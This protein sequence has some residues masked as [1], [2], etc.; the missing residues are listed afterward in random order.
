MI[1][2]SFDRVARLNHALPIPMDL[3]PDVGSRT[4]ILYH[5]LWKGSPTAPPFEELAPV[6][7]ESVKWVCAVHP[8][9][10]AEGSHA[11]NIDAFLAVLQQR[12]P[13]RTVSPRDYLRSK[14]RNRC[15]PSAGI[16]AIRDLL[17]FGIKEL[18]ISGFTFYQGKKP[19]HENYR[20]AGPTPW[21]HSP[22]RELAQIRRWVESDSRIRLDDTLEAIV[23]SGMVSQSIKEK[24]D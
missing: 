7:Q 18:F 23:A 1:I 16:S 2:D 13:F 22:D 11:D 6:L 24:E 8:Y 21:L 15:R 10:N 20:G 9:S 17:R 4:D 12:V 5:N 3:V 14:W 19:Y